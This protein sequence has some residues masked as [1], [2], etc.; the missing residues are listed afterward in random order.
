[1]SLVFNFL[2]RCIVV[3][4]FLRGYYNPLSLIVFLVCFYDCQLVFF[5]YACSIVCFT[6]CT[7]AIFT[8]L[9]S[10]ACT[11]VTCFSINTQLLK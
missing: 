9:N 11:F 1:M 4:G 8:A 3:F 10:V 7:I 6:F 5:S 2:P